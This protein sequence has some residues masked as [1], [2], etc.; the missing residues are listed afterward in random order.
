MSGS[1]SAVFGV[2]RTAGEALRAADALPGAIFT[3]TC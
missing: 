1:G 2:F 3:W